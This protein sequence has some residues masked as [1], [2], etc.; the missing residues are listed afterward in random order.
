MK[1]RVFLI[2]T[3]FACVLG[4]LA[5]SA[6]EEAR[7]I[8]QFIAKN[9]DG[10]MSDFSLFYRNITDSSLEI[11]AF[12]IGTHRVAFRTEKRFFN[13]EEYADPAL[14][15]SISP[16]IYFINYDIF[17][18]LEI[19]NQIQQQKNSVIASW[20]IS[21][22]E[23]EPSQIYLSEAIN[24]NMVFFH[25]TQ[26]DGVFAEIVKLMDG[27]NLSFA[28]LVA[29]HTSKKIVLTDLY[30]DGNQVKLKF[31]NGRVF[32][33]SLKKE[34]KSIELKPGESKTF[35]IELDQ[36]L[37]ES[38]DFSMKDFEF[39]LTELLWEIKLDKEQTILRNFWLVKFNG[40]LPIVIYDTGYK[41][42][43]PLT[44]ETFRDKKISALHNNEAL[45][46]DQEDTKSETKETTVNKESSQK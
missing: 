29:N 44:L 21:Y 26:K 39:G 19:R 22:Q 10:G 8:E 2:A 1:H 7:K 32:T 17:Q 34:A 4:G 18:E 27:N 23:K 13:F 40:E 28:L 9:I 14:V 5:A 35:K 37:N 16:G 45:G 3:L 6:A 33:P 41:L 12:F 36:L 20:Y 25:K 38:K 42:D 31:P 24:S 30:G 46:R 11:D 15:Y 43:G